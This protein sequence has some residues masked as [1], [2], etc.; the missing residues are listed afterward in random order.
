M[1][2]LRYLPTWIASWNVFKLKDIKAALKQQKVKLKEGDAVLIRTGFM[3][4]RKEE[5]AVDIKK[6]GCPSIHPS[7]L[8]YLHKKKIALLAS[9]TRI[10]SRRF[11]RVFCEISSDS[12]RM[13][14]IPLSI[15]RWNNL[16]IPLGLREWDYGCLIT[17]ISRKFQWNV[18][19]FPV[20]NSWWISFLFTCKTRQDHLLIRLRSSK[21]WLPKEE[22][23]KQ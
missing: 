15:R 10:H 2:S 12:Q 9:D 22:V 13:T 17:A 7:A 1:S 16:Y 4:R 19:P 6:E 23:G 14:S 20:T 3:K 11:L 21:L 5:G 8:P 18:N